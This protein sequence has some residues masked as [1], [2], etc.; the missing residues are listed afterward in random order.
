V[1]KLPWCEAG[2]GSDAKESKKATEAPADDKPAKADK[3]AKKPSAKSAA[4]K[5][6]SADPDEGGE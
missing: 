5:A 4:R 3:G 2:T 6:K 1:I